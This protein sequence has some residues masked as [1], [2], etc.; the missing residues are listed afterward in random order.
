MKIEIDKK[1]G[2]VIIFIAIMAFLAG[3]LVNNVR[4]DGWQMHWMGMHGSSSSQYSA[5]DIM[6]AQMMIPH[7]EQAI[8]MSDYALSTSNNKF[9]LAMAAQIK[10][11]QAPEIEQ[12]KKWLEDANAGMVMDHDMGMGGMLSD[13][14][15]ATL[16]ASKGDTFD[17][18]FLKG[19]IAHH[20]GAIAMV[21][22]IARSDNEEARALAASITK[23][24]KAEIKS[25]QDYLDTL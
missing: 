8:E 10:A 4:N 14:E 25:M 15:L 7:H 6:F 18:H 12:M 9:V 17:R 1:S 5:N 20:E 19:M 23:S 2:L 11:A 22:M 16:K 3:L 21:N 24:Q 13:Q